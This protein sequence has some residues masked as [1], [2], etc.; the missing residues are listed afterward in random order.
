MY[1]PPPLACPDSSGDGSV[2]GPRSGPYVREGAVGQ[3][4]P[5]LAVQFLRQ[6]P[7]TDGARLGW[8]SGQGGVPAMNSR[9]FTLRLWAEGWGAGGSF[10]AADPCWLQGQPSGRGESGGGGGVDTTNGCLR[11]G[12]LVIPG[13]RPHPLAPCS[14][15]GSL[16][17]V[18]GES[19]LLNTF[20]SNEQQAFH[21]Q[22]LI[23]NLNYRNVLSWK[24]HLVVNWKVQYAAY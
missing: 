14:A 19:S 4:E 7:G 10:C 9:W 16:Q 8:D 20:N 21:L 5:T 23:L 17:H 11:K 1:T 22:G 2:S 12:G 24:W 6:S 15:A 13:D 18:C 3:W